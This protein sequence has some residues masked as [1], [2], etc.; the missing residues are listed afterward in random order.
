MTSCSSFSAHEPAKLR[1]CCDLTSCSPFFAREEV[2]DVEPAVDEVED[3]EVEV[4]ELE[5]AELGSLRAS[6]EF[7]MAVGT[8]SATVIVLGLGFLPLTISKSS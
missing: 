8:K 2:V 4:L 7:L 1:C 6:N 3:A 5:S